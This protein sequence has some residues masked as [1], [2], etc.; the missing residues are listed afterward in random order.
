MLTTN[1]GTQYSQGEVDQGVWTLQRLHFSSME[2]AFVTS[3]FSI[4]CY[5]QNVTVIVATQPFSRIKEISERFEINCWTNKTYCGC[6]REMDKILNNAAKETT[7][8]GQC[9]KPK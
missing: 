8:L 4:N 6:D 1:V 7:T 2:Q 9:K 3:I 5:L